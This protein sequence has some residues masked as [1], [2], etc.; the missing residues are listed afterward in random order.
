MARSYITVSI[1]YVNARPHVGY[2]LELVEADVLARQ[3]RDAGGDVRFL[4]GTDDHALKNVL[5][6]E[7]EGVPTQV[8]VDRER[9]RVRS[10]ARS[11]PDL[12]RRLHPHE[13]R[14][15]PRAGCRAALAGVR[16]R[17]ATSTAAGT[18]AR[19]ASG[20]SGS[21]RRP[22]SSTA[23]VRSTARRTETVGEENWFFRLSR[24]RDQLVDLIERGE[25][26]IVPETYRNEVLAFLAGGL[27]DISV[28]RSQTRARGWGLP[29]PDDPSQ[30]DLRVVGRARELHH[31]ARLRDRRRGVRHVVARRRTNAS[32]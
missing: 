23:A 21:T 29:V 3:R 16:R 12:V 25:L 8:F 28:S 17:V 30:V 32:T 5:G 18:R 22:S 19:T 1:P 4:G 15:A 27:D 6:A 2:A 14:P 11:A 7:A 13:P 9:G 26:E 24:Y 20:A 10:A 31:R